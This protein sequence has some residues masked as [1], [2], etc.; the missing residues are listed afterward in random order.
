VLL[1]LLLP[2]GALLAQ[3]RQPRERLCLVDVAAIP[4][5]SSPL[6]RGAASFVVVI[7]SRSGGK[8]QDEE[9][10]GQG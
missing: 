7:G 9:G 1:L 2:L 6:G 10:H 5:T 4:S 3:R 8:G